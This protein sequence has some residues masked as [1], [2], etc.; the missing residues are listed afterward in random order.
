MNPRPGPIYGRVTCWF[1]TFNDGRSV[2][3]SFVILSIKLH[4]KCLPLLDQLYE[5]QQ[6]SH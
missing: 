3:D 1:A 5:G 6:D 2:K 4:Q